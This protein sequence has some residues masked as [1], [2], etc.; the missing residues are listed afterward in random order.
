[1]NDE[2]FQMMELSQQGFYCS[3]ILLMM[4]LKAQGKTNPDL[5]RS[6][7]G[8]AG[9]IGFC[10]KNCGSLTGGACL[11]SLYAS[12]GTA[13]EV[14]DERLRKMILDLV[15]WFVA[16]YSPIYGGIDCS[17][18]YGGD[19]TKKKE[20]CPQIILQTYQQVKEILRINGFDMS[21]KGAGA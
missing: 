10:G 18:I 7:A 21:G 17:I 1:M 15:E 16:K 20:R 5:I 6:M 11:L 19:L 3:Q 9:G 14:E 12:R 8:L 13:E 2:I 4:G